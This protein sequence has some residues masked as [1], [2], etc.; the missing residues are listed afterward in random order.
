MAAVSDRAKRKYLDRRIESAY[1]TTLIAAA[2][3][4]DYWFCIQI[5][6]GSCVAAG[7]EAG[8]E[9]P[10]PP[11]EKCLGNFTTSLCDSEAINLF[12]HCYSEKLPAAVF[13]SSDGVA[14]SFSDES[15]LDNLYTAVLYS[16]ATDVFEKAENDLRDYLPILS[17]K[18]S[19][20]DISLAAILD[21]DNIG[22]IPAVKGYDV[23]KEKARVRE[24]RQKEA[25]RIEAERKHIEEE[26]AR[27]EAERQN[28]LEAQRSDLAEKRLRLNDE[29]NKSEKKWTDF[30]VQQRRR[31]EEERRRI[32]EE[33]ARID[34]DIKN[35]A[36]E[37]ARIEERRKRREEAERQRTAADKTGPEAPGEENGSGADA[38]SPD[39]VK[40]TPEAESGCVDNREPLPEEPADT[41]QQA[42]P[43]GKGLHGTKRKTFLQ[44]IHERR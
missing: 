36:E 32:E 30:F 38:G 17:Q 15:R 5:G 43:S 35:N 42:L 1:G 3:T 33:I 29:Q 27:K 31:Q 24:N 19:G 8:F 9:Q 26:I 44:R 4:P 25:E 41:K 10:V 23:E 40:N 2:V 16:F 34:A 7:A 18:G 11:D 28:M 37:L 21:M 39:D 13:L 20:D 22:R 6:D 14:N 12:R